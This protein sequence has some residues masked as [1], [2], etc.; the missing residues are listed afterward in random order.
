MSYTLTYRLQAALGKFIIYT[1]EKLIYTAAKRKT[2]YNTDEFT[3]CKNVELLYPYI[4]QEVTKALLDYETIPELKYLSE[5]QERIVKGNRWKSLFFY[6]YG[7]KIDKNLD[8]FPYTQQALGHIPGMVTAFF[9]ILEPHTRLVPHRG[10]YGG[11]LRYHLG[12]IVP[13]E[14]EKCYLCIGNEK[15]QWE[16]GKSLIFDD[17]AEHY[18]VNDTEE[19][20]VV[21]FVDFKRPL[22]FPVNIL[23]NIIIFLIGSS[24]YIQKII[25]RV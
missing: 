11:V 19:L 6:A 1:A 9:S 23:N 17:T 24:P 10:T 18:A 13:G 15:R 12:L 4:Q 14:A 16:E 3:W 22:P 8:A 2:F 21:L 5:E 25:R 20:R 7:K